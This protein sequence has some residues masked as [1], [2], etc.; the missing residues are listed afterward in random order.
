MVIVSDIITGIIAGLAGALTAVISVRLSE[1]SKRK[2]EHHQKH[3]E[4]FEAL[5]SAIRSVCYE[6]CP[7]IGPGKKE[8]PFLSGD[9]SVNYK[10]W[11][12]YSIFDNLNVTE[13]NDKSVIIKHV[14][15]LLYEDINKHWPDFYREFNEWKKKVIETGIKS[16]EIMKTIFESIR[17]QVK[18]SK[19]SASADPSGAI[20]STILVVYNFV[21]D[22]GSDEWPNLYSRIKNEGVEDK[23]KKLAY[24]VKME[25]KEDLNEFYEKVKPFLEEGSKLIDKLDELIHYEKIRHGCG[26]IG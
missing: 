9:Y 2:F 16:N 7:Y 12:N 1:K 3:K 20:E 21:M 17:N 24:A 13:Q 15:L 11:K 18:D 26:F 22:T 10:F 8:E 6:I 19:I 25:R 23:L 4:N 5:E 14:D